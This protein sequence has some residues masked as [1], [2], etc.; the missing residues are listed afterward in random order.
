MPNSRGAQTRER[1]LAA[2]FRVA[3]RD[4]ARGVTLDAVAEEAGSSKGGLLYHFPT[5]DA[6]LRAMLSDSLDRFRAEIEERAA[7]D[8]EQLGRSARAYVGSSFAQD[9]NTGRWTALLTAMFDDPSLAEIWQERARTWVEVDRGEGG[10]VEDA[11]I[12]RLATDGLWLRELVGATAIP[13]GVRRRI[14]SRLIEMTRRPA[15]GRS[16]S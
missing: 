13:P 14:E 16:A 4:G 10:D 1:L 15:P 3:T 9:P 2:A 6:L 7:H 5:K 8:R 11:L 12:A